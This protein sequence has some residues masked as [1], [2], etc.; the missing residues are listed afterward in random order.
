MISNCFVLSQKVPLL[1]V[2]VFL[3]NA[4]TL[5][6]NAEI[7]V[8]SWSALAVTSVLCYGQEFF[9]VVIYGCYLWL[10]FF[11]SYLEVVSWLECQLL[12][13]YSFFRYLETLINSVCWLQ[14]NPVVVDA[15]EISPAHRARYFWG[16]LP[17]MNRWILTTSYRNNYVLLLRCGSRSCCSLNVNNH[18][19]K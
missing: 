4:W 13:C 7:H 12:Q 6:R 8:H 9:T 14:C 10:L 3:L 5:D 18:F 15:K 17:G 19:T 1:T 16:N 2:L 11:L